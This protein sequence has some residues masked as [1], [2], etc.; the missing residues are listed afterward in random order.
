MSVTAVVTFLAIF[1]RGA[2]FAYSAPV[3]G[4]KSIPHKVRVALVALAAALSVLAL[5]AWLLFV[6]AGR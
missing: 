6:S 5:A 4:D 3:I 1:V 2:A